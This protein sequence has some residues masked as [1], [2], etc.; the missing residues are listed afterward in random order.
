MM[1]TLTCNYRLYPQIYLFFPLKILKI[2]Q[3]MSLIQVYLKLFGV[4]SM[5]KVNKKPD[6]VP[7]VPDLKC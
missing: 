6:F 5:E 3:K 1:N 7:P 2:L 4:T